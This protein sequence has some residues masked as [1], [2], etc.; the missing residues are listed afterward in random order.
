LSWYSDYL[1]RRARQAS[2][3]STRTRTSSSTSRRA[4]SRANDP[5]APVDDRQPEAELHQTDGE[6]PPSRDGADLQVDAPGARG[7]VDHGA[8]RPALGRHDQPLPREIVDREPAPS[9]ERVLARND[10]HLLDGGEDVHAEP[11]RIRVERRDPHVRAPGPHGLDGR[12]GVEG[13][14]VQRARRPPLVGPQGVADDVQQ[15]SGAGRNHQPTRPSFPSQAGEQ[16]QRPLVVLPREGRHLDPLRRE[17]QAAPDAAVEGDPQLL[18]QPPQLRVD[19]R[20]RE[21]QPPR[22]ARHVRVLGEGGERAKPA[23]LDHHRR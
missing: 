16:L 18:G 10:E 21:V 17:L 9:R 15:G 3:F 23:R 19:R 7:A 12:W 2:P 11:L 6:V 4:R 1:P 13:E 5:A 14:Q 8:V 20:L 22:G